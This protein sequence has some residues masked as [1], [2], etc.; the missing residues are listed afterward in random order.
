MHFRNPEERLKLIENIADRL[1]PRVKSKR[2]ALEI[3]R[4]WVEQ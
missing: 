4:K 3:A 1:Q 2:T